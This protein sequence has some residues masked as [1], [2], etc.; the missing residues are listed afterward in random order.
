MTKLPILAAAAACLLSA[1][2][3]GND[4]EEQLLA[5]CFHAI[6]KNDWKTYARLTL[7]P[8]EILEKVSGVRQ[9]SAF[10]RRQGFAGGV[11]RPEQM[12][13][14]EQSFKRAVR[15]G[16][17]Q[18]DFARSELDGVGTLLGTQDPWRR[19]GQ[20]FPYRTYSLR[21]KTGG[22]TLD[23]KDLR[24]LFTVVA[25]EGKQRLIDLVF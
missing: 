9:R 6:K 13:L 7:T 25:W 22:R 20:S 11:L 3:G 24:P 21:I 18:I 1:C 15:G 19:E 17:G 23:T 12:K 8:A 5:S 4:T 2:K 14:H 10:K 16:P